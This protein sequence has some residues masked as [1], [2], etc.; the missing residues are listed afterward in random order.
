MLLVWDFF[1]TAAINCFWKIW[2]VLKTTFKLFTAVVLKRM[3]GGNASGSTAAA[4]WH[5]LTAEEA[6]AGWRLLMFL[7]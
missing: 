1:K 3:I 2:E 5:Q 7:L 4:V 6:E